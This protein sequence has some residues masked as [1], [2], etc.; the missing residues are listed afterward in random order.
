MQQV[1]TFKYLGVVI[2]SDG[3][4]NKEVDTRIRKKKFSLSF[5]ALWSQTV[6]FK[7]RKA[8]SV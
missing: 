8:G 3:R 4:R 2:T 6:A 1:E 5:I 7:H